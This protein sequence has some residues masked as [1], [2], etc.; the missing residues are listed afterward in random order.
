M[1]YKYDKENTVILFEIMKEIQSVRSAYPKKKEGK[2]NC[3]LVK[4][5]AQPDFSNNKY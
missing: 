5:K 1:Q 4:L 2:H 3:R